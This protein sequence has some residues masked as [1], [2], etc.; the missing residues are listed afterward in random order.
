MEVM[1]NF[2][3]TLG[4]YGRIF[5]HIFPLGGGEGSF[6]VKLPCNSWNK[7]LCPGICTLKNGRENSLRS[8]RSLKLYELAS[9]YHVM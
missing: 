1:V 4:A 5:H 7:R 6:C 8:F 3:P 2:G 9:N